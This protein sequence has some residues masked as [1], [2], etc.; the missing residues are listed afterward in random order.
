MLKYSHFGV[1]KFFVDERSGLDSLS[2]K[3]NWTK[4]LVWHL[5]IHQF[6]AM[7][8][9]RPVLKLLIWDRVDCW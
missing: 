9:S 1:G 2:T 8:F 7:R 5:G 6:P 3:T 4:K